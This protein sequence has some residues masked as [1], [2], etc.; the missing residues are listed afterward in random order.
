[1]KIKFEVHPTITGA[2]VMTTGEDKIV[3]TLEE[4]ERMMYNLQDVVLAQY[5]KK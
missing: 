4:A 5:K 1:M 2:V 3:L